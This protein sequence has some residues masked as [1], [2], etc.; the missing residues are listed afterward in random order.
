MKKERGR[1]QGKRFQGEM[2]YRNLDSLPRC[3][4]ANVVQ[5]SPVPSLHNHIEGNNL[6]TLTKVGQLI[7]HLMSC[8][9]KVARLTEEQLKQTEQFRK[10]YVPPCNILRFF[11]EQ[12]VGCAV[13]AKKIYNVV[14]KIKKNRMQGRN[15]VEEVLY[16]SAQWGYT[17]FYRNGE[18]NNVLSDIVV[19]HPTSIAMIRTCPYVL[20]MDTTY[21]TNKFN[22][23][24]VLIARLG[25]TT[26]LSLYS[27]STCTVET[28]CIRYLLEQ[29]HFIQMRDGCSLSPLQFQWQYHRDIRVSGCA[30]HY[31]GRIADWVR[32]ARA[33]Y[34]PQGPIHVHIS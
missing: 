10:S 7:E 2:N 30:E 19:A 31:Y 5:T 17:V 22:F 16:L 14:A 24:V 11:Q 26:V 6:K 34:P 13:N 12:N 4:L 32:R 25:S 15:T 23:C 18:D 8:T 21:K 28:L 33:E 9:R 20:I 27:N 3:E 1:K 29:Q